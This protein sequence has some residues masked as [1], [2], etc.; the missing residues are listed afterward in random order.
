MHNKNTLPL[1]VFLLLALL[2]LPVPGK[3]AIDLAEL[4]H[5]VLRAPVE[6]RQAGDELTLEE[7]RNRT[8]APLTA[9]DVNRG[10]TADAYWIRV[11]L[12]NR[13]SDRPR[14]WILHH[15]TSYLDNFTVHYADT[16][17]VFR[18]RALSDR[19]PFHRRP[20][21]Y[22]MLAFSHSTPA[23]QYTDVYLKLRNQKA[24]AVSLNVHLWDAD[25]FQSAIQ[26]ENLFHG[27][28]FGILLTLLTVALLCAYLLRQRVY[29]HYAIFLLLT[30]LMWA[31]INGYAYQYLWPTSVFWHNEGFHIVYL[32]FSIA[33]LQFSR[34]FL[35]TAQRTPVVD[36]V[37]LGV[38]LVMAG[39]ILLRFLG[40]YE[41]VLY[42]SYAALAV[43]SLLSLLGLHAYREGLRY[44]RWYVV[45]W[46]GYGI[47]LVAGV[48]SASTTLLSWG[49]QPLVYTQLG[50]LFEA[51]LLMVALGERLAGW[52]KDRV[53]ALRLA[54]QD[55][56]TGLGNRRALPEAFSDLADKHAHSG[57]PAF[58]LMI[59]LDRFKEIN[60]TFG[61]EAGD[62]VLL[63]IA[64]MLV[65]HSRSHD[66]CI[67]YGG[68]EFAML[69]QAPS[70]ADAFEVAERIRQEFSRTPTL[71]QG[72]RIR[73]TLSAGLVQALPERPG[74]SMQSLLSLADQALYMA[75]RAG[76][77]QVVV[78]REPHAA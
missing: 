35:R 67:R 2:P 29:V 36:R 18:V 59:D 26:R 19:V 48:L 20:V 17:D 50:S 5:V 53:S 22:R 64:D 11:R 33:A 62:A 68:E 74:V 75:K 30:I 6:F 4:D 51:F 65:R 77:D 42:L 28:Y 73:H 23:G 32:L 40:F 69:F 61:H 37:L 27:A 25:A 41:P 10:I 16:G 38:Q 71:H 76:R 47:G 34:G 7:V 24:D 55:P 3:P 39:G 8:F 56:L 9:G 57:L 70:A 49:M 21:D 78:V 12:D 66:T 15:E 1:L 14:R 52:D 63:H 44:A 45:A 31:L 13:R 54:S 60:D 43:L 46:L 72:R 58:M